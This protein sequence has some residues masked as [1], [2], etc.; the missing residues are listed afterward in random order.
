MRGRTLNEL[1]EGVNRLPDNDFFRED[2][3]PQTIQSKWRASLPFYLTK[4]QGH[5]ADLKTC[6]SEAE[7]GC[8]QSWECGLPAGPE[9][10]PRTR[11]GFPRLRQVRVFRDLPFKPLSVSRTKT[12][13]LVTRPIPARSVCRCARHPFG[14]WPG[15]TP[16]Q[17]TDTD[18]SSQNPLGFC[19]E[20]S[21]P[22][23]STCLAP[24]LGSSPLCFRSSSSPCSIRPLSRCV[25][26][27]SAGGRRFYP[28]A[29][30]RQ[31]NV[32]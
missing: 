26:A 20:S 15:P 12:G 8:P 25:R 16:S 10:R 11:E 28:L 24:A 4:R 2:F 19:P 31:G 23:A 14:R 3:Q 1:G 30:L 27:A 5:V 22:A 6:H 17:S 9:G 13:G 7:G 32:R 21:S 18:V 29:I